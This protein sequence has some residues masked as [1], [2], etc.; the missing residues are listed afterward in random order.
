MQKEAVLTIHLNLVR[1]VTKQTTN[2][3]EDAGKAEYLY[4]WWECIYIS[5]ATS[6]EISVVP[7]NR[8]QN[9]YIIQVFY[10]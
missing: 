10:Y 8:R 5:G 6:V 7:D 1:M 4:I 3:G 2:G 9:Y